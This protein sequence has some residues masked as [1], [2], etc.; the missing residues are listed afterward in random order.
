[1]WFFHFSRRQMMRFLFQRCVGTLYLQTLLLLGLHSRS[2]GS[3][4]SHLLDLPKAGMWTDV[5]D[6]TVTSVPGVWQKAMGSHPKGLAVWQKKHSQMIELVIIQPDW[7]DGLIIKW[8]GIYILPKAGINLG[9]SH[10]SKLNWCFLF[11][12]TTY[13]NPT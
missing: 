1:M 3:W 8:T 6:L 11:I 5:D 9:F 2:A 12:I 10:G 7:Y 4:E 13:H